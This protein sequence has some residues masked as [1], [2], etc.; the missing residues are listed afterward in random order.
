M[1]FVFLIINIQYKEYILSHLLST[2]E[3]KLCVLCGYNNAELTEMVPTLK[4]YAIR[5]SNEDSERLLH[6][7][8]FHLLVLVIPHGRYGPFL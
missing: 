2:N 3:A 6:A 5:L 1:A 8:N 4:K 7:G